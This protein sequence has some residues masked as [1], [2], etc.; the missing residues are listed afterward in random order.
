MRVSPQTTAKI[1]IVLE[2]ISKSDRI[3]LRSNKKFL[4]IIFNIFTFYLNNGIFFQM[5]EE[6]PAL[7]SQFLVSIFTLV[8]NYSSID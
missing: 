4:P 5:V 6:N 7:T 8:K 3:S 1:I 2:E